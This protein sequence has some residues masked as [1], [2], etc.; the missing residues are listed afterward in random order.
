MILNDFLSRQRHD[1]GDPHDII[2]ITLT[3]TLYYTKIL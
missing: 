2:P 1:D 3:C